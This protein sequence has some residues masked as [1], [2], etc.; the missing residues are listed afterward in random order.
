MSVYDSSFT[1]HKTHRSPKIPVTCRIKII[2]MIIVI[3][4]KII[5]INHNGL[6]TSFCWG[7]SNAVLKDTPNRVL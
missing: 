5:I 2:I 6:L 3:M 1:I 7:S 4:I